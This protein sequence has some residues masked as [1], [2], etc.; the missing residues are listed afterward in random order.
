MS[1]RG[2]TPSVVLI[3]PKFPHNLAATL[4][5]AS[6][7][8]ARQV[9]YTGTRLQR[10]MDS[11]SRIP[12]EERMRGYRHVEVVP[13]QRPFDHFRNAVPVAVEVREN[14]ECLT[15]FEHPEDAIYVFGPEDGSIPKPILHC[16]HR[17][18]FI[19]T[20]HCLNLSQSVNLV[21]GHRRLYAQWTGREQVPLLGDVLREERGL[22]RTPSVIDVVGWDGM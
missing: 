19:P 3:N 6:C 18:V 11:L 15:F 7:W 22:P 13:D 4:R 12:R 14:S 9:W 5:A 1:I 20:H 8:G 10:K 16:C 17:F 21:L 2:L